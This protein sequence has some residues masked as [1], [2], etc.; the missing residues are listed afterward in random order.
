MKL[1]YLIQKDS[2]NFLKVRP[3]YLKELERI[4]KGPHRSFNSVQ[5]LREYLEKNAHISD[6]SRPRKKA[7]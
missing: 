6:K 1:S 7:I 3:E 5:E 2:E 4:R